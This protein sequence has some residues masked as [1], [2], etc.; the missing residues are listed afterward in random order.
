MAIEQKYGTMYAIINLP[1][2]RSLFFLRMRIVPKVD[3]VDIVE[4]AMGGDW[5]QTMKMK[6]IKMMRR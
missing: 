2:G 6:V 4:G 3:C 5:M 1:D